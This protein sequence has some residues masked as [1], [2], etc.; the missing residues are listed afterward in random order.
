MNKH[1]RLRAEVI[2][3]D[4]CCMECGAPGEEVHHIISR[5][6]D[7]AW[8]V[9]NMI[10]LCKACHAVAGNHWVKVRHIRLLTRRYGYDYENMGELW[11]A[12]VREAR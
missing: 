9:R 1:N 11:Q 8:D 4:G 6:Y 3:R 7:D 12:L 5:R 2:E 10:F